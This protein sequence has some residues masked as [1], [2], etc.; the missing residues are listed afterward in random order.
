MAKPR[1]NHHKAIYSLY[2]V[3]LNFY[4]FCFR[5]PYT[6]CTLYYYKIEKSMNFKTTSGPKDFGRGIVAL[7]RVICLTQEQK[8]ATKGRRMEYGEG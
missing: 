5:S 2:S 6:V 7:V 3:S 4:T 1:L 8:F